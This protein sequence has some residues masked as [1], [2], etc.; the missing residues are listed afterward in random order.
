MHTRDAHTLHGIASF[1]SCI[2][3]SQ[4][5]PVDVTAAA[6][7]L[8]L[9]LVATGGADGSIRVWD[10]QSLIPDGPPALEWRV[11]ASTIGKRRARGAPADIIATMVRPTSSATSSRPST[12]SYVSRP[13]SHTAAARPV[14]VD[15]MGSPARN[16]SGNASG[17]TSTVDEP[18]SSV[19]GAKK[20]AP[21]VDLLSMTFLAPW[22]VLVTGDAAGRIGLWKVRSLAH[23]QYRKNQ[24]LGRLFV[25][26]PGRS[27]TALVAFWALTGAAQRNRASLAGGS[28]ATSPRQTDPGGETL[29]LFA[30]DERGWIQGWQVKYLLDEHFPTIG[31]ISEAKMPM[32]QNTYNPWAR[33][34]VKT[35]DR[36]AIG[37]FE[38]PP[39]MPIDPATGNP[40]L[41]PAIAP[42]DVKF[43]AHD[44]TILSLCE[45][46]RVA[47]PGG[48]LL[49]SAF[50][51]SF[52]IWSID[53]ACLGRISVQQL[54]GGDMALPSRDPAVEWLLDPG[55]EHRKEEEQD[56]AVEILKQI[57]QTAER[58]RLAAEHAAGTGQISSYAFK[59]LLALS[60][61]RSAVMLKSETEE[62][63]KTGNHARKRRSSI[64]GQMFGLGALSPK[65]QSP[66][67]TPSSSPRPSPR[68]P[69]RR[70]RSGNIL[71][72]TPESAQRPQPAAKPT[73]ISRRASMQRRSKLKELNDSEENPEVV[74][75]A[76]KAKLKYSNLCVR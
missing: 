9:S 18:V 22:P 26:K 50:D 28:L 42:P 5:H 6:Y 60:R 23:S 62:A 24:F 19:D 17:N 33:K 68:T 75:K 30:A 14:S 1:F 73:G 34:P 11:N 52:A 21:S 13:T 39:L 16:T 3:F 10:F 27:V 32:V 36:V 58:Q 48:A 65:S 53:G 25:S 64:M 44:T 69:V 7:S 57:A 61:K 71:P 70:K 4:T 47:N 66:K 38:R 15:S 37:E 2:C 63:S 56:K 49:S 67:G 55:V 20:K 8:E 40:W 43:R 12:K 51:G 74:V 45:A 76:S 54:P 31:K 59:A 35:Y 72:Q 46:S 41:L 29:W